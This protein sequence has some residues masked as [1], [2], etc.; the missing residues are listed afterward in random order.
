MITISAISLTL[1]GVLIS[2][3]SVAFGFASAWG[4]E[5]NAVKNLL[6]LVAKL[7]SQIDSLR[8]QVDQLKL[9][10]ARLEE[11]SGMK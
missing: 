2:V 7:E 9:T 4:A 3:F 8:G 5:R 1:A 10:V 6:V 11:R